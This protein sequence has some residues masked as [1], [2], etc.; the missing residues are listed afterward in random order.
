MSEFTADLPSDWQIHC[1]PQVEGGQAAAQELLDGTPELTALFAYNDL[2]AVGA[3]RACEEAGLNVP[4]DLAIIGCDDIPLAALVSPALTTI[5]I[6]TY[7]LGQHTMNL[8]LQMV[9]Q[10]QD[11]RQSI[12]VSPHLVIRDSSG[13]AISQQRSAS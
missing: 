8:L 6:P 4:R 13:P 9:E 7:N 1:P 11:I 2:V 3:L 10:G 5:H 12:V